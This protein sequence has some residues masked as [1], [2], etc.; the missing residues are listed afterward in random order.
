VIENVSLSGNTHSKENAYILHHTIKGKT[1]CWQFQISHNTGNIKDPGQSG[2][3]MFSSVSHCFCF[4]EIIQ[5][6]WKHHLDRVRLLR[7]DRDLERERDLELED[8]ER[9][10]PP[11]RRVSSTNRILRPFSSVSSS[12]SMAFLMSECVA[13]STTL[14]NKTTY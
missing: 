14:E 9:R 7:R 12:L 13:N 8:R 4:V 3:Q 11:L 5:N 1:N 6:N 2:H 10:L